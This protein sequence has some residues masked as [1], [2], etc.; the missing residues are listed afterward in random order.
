MYIPK[1]PKKNKIRKV[2]KLVKKY[3]DDSKI[4]DEDNFFA[5]EGYQ[6]CLGLLKER[7]K[8][9]KNNPYFNPE[10]EDELEPHK[11]MYKKQIL[12]VKKLKTEKGRAIAIA[13]IE[14]LNGYEDNL[15][16]LTSVTL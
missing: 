7:V 12:P 9:P 5:K 2:I 8:N 4:E 16:I 14:Y 6:F 10:T 3:L 13:C 1:F 11:E 15:K